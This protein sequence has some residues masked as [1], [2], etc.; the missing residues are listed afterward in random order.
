MNSCRVGVISKKINIS[1]NLMMK[2]G[3]NFVLRTLNSSL[4]YE[5]VVN[6]SLIGRD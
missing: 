4:D 2:F 1:V 6:S 5:I 3:A